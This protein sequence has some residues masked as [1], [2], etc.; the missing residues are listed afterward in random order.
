MEIRRVDKDEKLATITLTTEEVSKITS[1][2]Q[3]TALEKDVL[4]HQLCFNLQIVDM[5][6]RN[7]HVEA[8]YE[9][10]D[11]YA[12]KET[13]LYKVSGL[14]V[15]GEYCIYPLEDDGTKG[16]I[17]RVVELIS[18][19]KM[20]VVE[21]CCLYKNKD[22][23]PYADT[24]DYVPFGEVNHLMESVQDAVRNLSLY[25]EDGTKG[26]E[27][28][29]VSDLP[30]IPDPSTVP[31]GHD[32]LQVSGNS[33]KSRAEGPA[34][35]LSKIMSSLPEIPKPTVKTL[36]F[37]NEDL[38]YATNWLDEHIFQLWFGED[39]FLDEK[40]D[41][42]MIFFEY[43]TDE[44]KWIVEIRWEEDFEIR[45]EQDSASWDSL[46]DPNAYITKTEIAE[47]KKIAEREMLHSLHANH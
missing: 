18:K 23:V 39:H 37:R 26:K 9:E 46:V 30:D 44:I 2:L 24:E 19:E 13:L 41:L 17:I 29:S 1:I 12:T 31:E 47:I 14:R 42:Y 16:V 33:E 7:G 40:G 45:W 32:P 25:M 34:L 8:D 43:H 10:K 28:F 15:P 6:L 20:Y 4:Y 36:R 22:W 38:P 27:T 21:E 11:P 35:D 3:A 5:L